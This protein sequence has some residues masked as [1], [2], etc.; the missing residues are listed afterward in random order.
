MNRDNISFLMVP[1]EKIDCSGPWLFFKRRPTPFTYWSL[2]RGVY[3]PIGV[4][5]EGD[6]TYSAIWGCEIVEACKN[7]GSVLYC[8]VMELSM[9]DRGILHLE[10]EGPKE[11]RPCDFISCVRFFSKVLDGES[12][13]GKGIYDILVPFLSRRDLVFLLKWT[14]LPSAWDTL[15]QSGHLSLECIDILD[16]FTPVQL[17]MI[18]PLFASLAWGRNKALELLETLLEIS[19]RGDDSWERICDELQQICDLDLSPGD[20]IARILGHVRAI[21]NPLFS[22]FQ[23]KV[24]NRLAGMRVNKHWRWKTSPGFETDSL[25]L[26]V[27]LNEEY[28]LKDLRED[29]VNIGERWEKFYKWYCGFLGGYNRIDGD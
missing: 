5:R 18:F 10:V 27:R 17:E 25:L 3:P 19:R 1:P 28:G 15:L 24:W 20:K 8:W 9:V 2:E 12:D 16:K 29:L 6:D 22:E 23:R 26:E 11:G 7:Q 4:C 21:R 14:Q 13:R